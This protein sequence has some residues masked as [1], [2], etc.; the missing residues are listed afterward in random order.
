M[1]EMKTVEVR[2]GLMGAAGRATWG[3]CGSWLRRRRA[4]FHATFFHPS[5]FLFLPECTLRLL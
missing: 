3:N 5:H 1:S 4:R 2:V